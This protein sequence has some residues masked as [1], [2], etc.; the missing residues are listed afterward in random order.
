M[1]SE[2]NSRSQDTRIDHSLTPV[3][4]FEGLKSSDYERAKKLKK[5]SLNP[6]NNNTALVYTPVI[7]IDSIQHL[8]RQG[9]SQGS[10]AKRSYSSEIRTRQAMYQ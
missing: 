3:H 7:K 1:V 6:S 2:I 9:C 4:A 5:R 10:L 8:D